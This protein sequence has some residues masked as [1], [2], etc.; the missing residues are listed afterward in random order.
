MAILDQ[1][2]SHRV[3]V[4]SSRYLPI[5]VALSRFGYLL[6]V[7]LSRVFFCTICP[8]T[9]SRERS[10]KYENFDVTGKRRS[11]DSQP[12]DKSVAYR[13]G[14]DLQMLTPASDVLLQL[15]GSLDGAAT[16]RESHFLHDRF[17]RCEI[18][19][20]YPGRF[21]HFDVCEHEN[22]TRAQV[23]F[24][25]CSEAVDSTVLSVVQEVRCLVWA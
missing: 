17:D 15:S 12:Q 7:D 4:L 1:D 9:R 24:G 20:A 18:A 16:L 5:H 6:R 3:L 13:V 25:R 11:S 22:G 21:V 2:D 23:S 19:L 10:T 14:A 8:R